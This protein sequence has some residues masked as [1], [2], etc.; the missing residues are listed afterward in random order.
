MG[1]IESNLLKSDLP[2]AKPMDEMAS[3]RAPDNINQLI[4]TV[5]QCTNVQSRRP[6][7]DMLFLPK[8]QSLYLPVYGFAEK[9][10]AWCAR[11]CTMAL[12]RYGLVILA[13][14][15]LR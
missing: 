1:Y 2:L 14:K 13:S 4:V 10:P 7:T 11:Q 12:T 3:K 8:V 9:V 15:R 6:G 5:M